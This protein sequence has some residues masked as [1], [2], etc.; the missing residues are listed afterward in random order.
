ME[1]HA[2]SVDQEI[3]QRAQ[4]EI[5][6]DEYASIIKKLYIEDKKTLMEVAEIMEFKYGFAAK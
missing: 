4:H 5:R 1:S 6:W 3:Q 2:A